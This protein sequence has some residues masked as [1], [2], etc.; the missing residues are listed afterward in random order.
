MVTD[1]ANADKFE[2]FAF[3]SSERNWLYTQKGIQVTYVISIVRV[4]NLAWMTGLS[5]RFSN[6]FVVGEALS[7][8][9]S[10]GVPKMLRYSEY[11]RLG[12]ISMEIILRN[13]S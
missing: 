9:P 8:F 7:D 6:V 3:I 13:S 11:L 5:F 12:E 4:F 1:E 10:P 2:R